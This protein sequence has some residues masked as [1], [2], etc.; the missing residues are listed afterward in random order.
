MTSKK[1]YMYMAAF[2]LMAASGYGDCIP[3]DS[4]PKELDKSQQKKCKSCA[5][6]VKKSYK[7]SCPWHSVVGP[8]EAACKEH[9]KKKK[10]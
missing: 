2:G 4:T 3:P 6:F 10:R 5:N 8:W 1:D 9:Y 7:G